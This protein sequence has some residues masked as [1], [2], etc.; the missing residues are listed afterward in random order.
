VIGEP[1]TITQIHYSGATRA[2][3]LATC[4]RGD[5][6]YELSLAH[7]L[8][9]AASAG[10]SFVE[11]YR[12]WLGLAPSAAPGIEAARPHKVESDDIVISE[13]LNLVV[14]ACK[15]NALRC[16]LLGSARE[17]TLRMAVRRDPWLDHHRDAEEAVDTRAASVP[18]RK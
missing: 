3:L 14:L 12:A 1:V 18:L 8:F 6:S 9:P 17:L 7:V 11:R 2:G 4:R 10:A 15:T 16:R 5:R 13:P